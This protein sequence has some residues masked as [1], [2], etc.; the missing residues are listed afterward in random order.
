ML[1]RAMNTWEPLTVPLTAVPAKGRGHI[2]IQEARTEMGQ[3]H[4]HLPDSS[5]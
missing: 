1:D 3:S 4:D 5:S 2:K